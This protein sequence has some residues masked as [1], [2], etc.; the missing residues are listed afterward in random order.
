[1][2]RIIAVADAF[3]AMTTHRPYQQAMS[4]QQ[5]LDRLNVLKKVAFDERVVEAFNR[6]YK[7]GLIVPDRDAGERDREVR[8]EP[9]PSAV[10]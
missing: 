2:A 4:F 6:A 5:A 3:D 1:M 8:R 9:E 7:Q 10:A